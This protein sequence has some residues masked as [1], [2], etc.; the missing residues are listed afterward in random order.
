[1]R[2][3]HSVKGPKRRIV[4]IDEA[5]VVVRQTYPGATKEG[6]AGSWSFYHEGRIVAEAWLE[7]RGNGWWLRIAPLKK[8]KNDN[9]S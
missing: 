1:M 3:I 7:A 5:L 6:S 4:E 8:D 2:D 9:S